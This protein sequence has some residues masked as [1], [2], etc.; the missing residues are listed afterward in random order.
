LLLADAGAK[1]IKVEPPEGDYTRG[2]GQPVTGEVGAVFY[3]LNR[4]KEG[5]RLDL[6]KK[7]HRERLRELLNGADILIEE[8]GQVRMR[9]LGLGYQE[10]AKEN[11]GL[12]YCTIT[13]HGERGPLRNQP[14]SELTLQAMS[15]FLNMLGVPGEEPVRMGPDMASLGTSLYATHGILGA[16]Y[17]K[18]RTGEGQHVTVSMLG[19]ILFQRGIN[20]LGTKNPD[21]WNGFIDYMKPPDQ[22]YQ[23]K[24]RRI[25]L[26][27]IQNQE[28]IPALLNALGMGS[29]VE[30]PLFQRPMREIMGLGGTS[31][32]Y[33][34]Q[35]KPVWE[36]AFKNWDAE[37]LVDLL[38]R[39]GSSAAVV[40][41]YKDLLSNQQI[42]AME[43]FREA[44]GPGIG[45]IQ[46]QTEPWKLNGVPRR[47]PEPYVE[48][49]I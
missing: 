18:W 20:W 21:D 19:S 33:G 11:P 35:A 34:Y 15:D 42:E 43:I 1:V 6:R 23:A 22:G 17:H 4:N 5:V 8:E 16:L 32:D 13:P 28:E 12:V 49:V 31:A 48:T 26:G 41:S 24:D 45:K 37:Q 46:F 44:S 3:H 38:C 25:I 10:L 36:G 14:A 30:T 9:R 27:P 40:C 7:G 2:W 47:T 39:F 29:Y